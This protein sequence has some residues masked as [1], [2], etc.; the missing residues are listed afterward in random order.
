MLRERPKKR[1]KRQKKKK[2]DEKEGMM[3]VIK[4]AGERS[5]DVGFGFGPGILLDLEPRMVV[6]FCL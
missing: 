1:Q 6:A 5:A 4:G 3:V 2:D